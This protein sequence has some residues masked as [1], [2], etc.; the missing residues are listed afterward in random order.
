V[1]GEDE[2]W[3]YAPFDTRRESPIR[4]VNHDE[5]VRIGR[6]V[7]LSEQVRIERRG[8]GAGAYPP[9][10]ERVLRPI[11]APIRRRLLSSSWLSPD[12]TFPGDAWTRVDRERQ[13]ISAATGRLARRMEVIY[14]ADPA[15]LG[16][17]ARLLVDSK[18]KVELPI[19]TLAGQ[20]AA[21]VPAGEHTVTMDGL[22]DSGIAYAAAAPAGGGAIMRR[23]DVHELTPQRALE[24]RFPQEVGETLHV[25][26][27]IAVEGPNTNFALRYEIDGGTPRQTIGHFS[28]IAT[29]P[30]GVL[31]GRTGDLGRGLLWEGK[32]DPRSPNGGP[33]GLAR[34]KVHLG[35]DLAQGTRTVRLIWSGADLDPPAPGRLWI[36]AVLV[37]RGPPVRDGS[38]RLWVDEE[39]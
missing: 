31:L 30:S 1:L 21:D 26:L 9:R 19:A 23:R 38:H 6:A 7:S 3:R 5:L 2:I 4:A 36:A 13:L 29:V 34:V 37:G 27:L 39:P 15:R 11:G 20:L 33:D 17:T 16:E 25:V 10:P 35:D 24:Y 18:A 8:D 12:G 14:R 32:G 22:G 28:R